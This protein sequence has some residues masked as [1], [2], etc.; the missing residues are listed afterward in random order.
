M[1]LSLERHLLRYLCREDRFGTNIELVESRYITE[2]GL[3]TDE[4]VY[5]RKTPLSIR[6]FC[7]QAEL[8]YMTPE[9]IQFSD[10][11]DV[12]RGLSENKKNVCYYMVYS[13]LEQKFKDIV[14][15]LKSLARGL[16]YL[17]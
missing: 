9:K 2:N 1:T 12:Q 11:L 13:E 17:T 7:I 16:D 4:M 5:L 6:N 8:L 3:I 10:Y 15:V 14:P